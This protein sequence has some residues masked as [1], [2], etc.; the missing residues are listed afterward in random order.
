MSRSTLQNSGNKVKSPIKYW[1]S[2]KGDVGKFQYWDGEKNVQVDTVDLLVLDRRSTITG[3]ND[4]TE[5]RIFSNAVKSLNEELNVRAKNKT[6]AK[7]LWKDIKE[8]VNQVGGNFT[9]NLYT[10]AKLGDAEEFEPACLQLDK[11][12]LKSWTDFL[13][14]HKLWEVYKGLVHVERGEEQKKGKVKF[15]VAEFTLNESN[16]DLNKQASEFDMEQLQP[17]FNGEEVKE[18]KAPF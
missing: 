5:S 3:W 15:F 10:L 18:E 11:S 7:G 14:N 13:D 16:E 9:V 17:Y 8:T 2:W 6:L 4:E 1:L 12:C